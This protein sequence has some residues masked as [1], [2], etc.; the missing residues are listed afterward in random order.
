MNLT[1]NHRQVRQSIATHVL[2]LGG[3]DRL[4]E[5]SSAFEVWFEQALVNLPLDRGAVLRDWARREWNDVIKDSGYRLSDTRPAPARKGVPAKLLA[6]D[7][8]EFEDMRVWCVGFARQD[9]VPKEEVVR[10]M[11]LAW[12]RLHPTEAYRLPDINRFYQG[13]LRD[14]K[15]TKAS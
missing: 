4:G 15:K 3:W 2:Q 5:P 1:G 12:K 10:S 13:V 11:G 14:A 8:G 9:I 6:P 7:Q